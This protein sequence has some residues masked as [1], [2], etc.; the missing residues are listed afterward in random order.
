MDAKLFRGREHI[1]RP[2]GGP[3]FICLKRTSA[4]SGSAKAEAGK[5][6]LYP[7]NPPPNSLF[8]G[9]YVRLSPFAVFSW[10]LPLPRATRL[11]GH[12]ID[13]R[14]DSQRAPCMSP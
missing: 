5:Q 3:N 14:S 8:T 1:G 13:L 7:K 12:G 10:R 11:N 6:R 9:R 2:L 4:C